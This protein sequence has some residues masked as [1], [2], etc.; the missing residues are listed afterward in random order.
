M[1]TDQL[2]YK[3]GEVFPLWHTLDDLLS[4]APFTNMD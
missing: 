4:V 2:S 1:V 3:P